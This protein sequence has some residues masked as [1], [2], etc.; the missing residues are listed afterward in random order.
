MKKTLAALG[1]L[2]GLNTSFFAQNIT[3]TASELE[4]ILTKQWEIE[5]AM[6]GSMKIGQVP[7]AKDFDVLFKRDGKYD[8]IEDDGTIRNGIWK[9]VTKNNY[10][11][12]SIDGKVTTRIKSINKS[13]LIL[14][15]VSEDNDA[16]TL[17]NVEIHFK[18]I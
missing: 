1:F 13:K 6:M 18:P 11:E 7:G 17:P 14:I 3:L 12:L 15:M 5:Y 9:Y 2:I 4:T 16:P 8:L 10:I